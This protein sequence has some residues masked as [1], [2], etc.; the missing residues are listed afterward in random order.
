ML[1][2]LSNC[3]SNIFNFTRIS[4]VLSS[5]RRFATKTV[6]KQPIPTLNFYETDG[7]TKSVTRETLHVPNT[8]Q[9]ECVITTDYLIYLA[10]LITKLNYLRTDV[11]EIF[12]G[13]GEPD[14]SSLICF[15]F[16]ASRSSK[17]P[18]LYTVLNIFC[19]NFLPGIKATLALV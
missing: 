17:F 10:N 1:F 19:Y 18:K 6:A 3:R 13:V 8:L 7:I 14:K 12:R 15:N 16:F 11:E 9:S 2:R 4:A 5:N